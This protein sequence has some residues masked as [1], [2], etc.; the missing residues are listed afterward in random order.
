MWKLFLKN[1]H[2]LLTKK[3]TS[4]LSAAFVIMV[5][6]AASRLL[7]LFRNRV[8]AGYFPVETLSLYFAAFRLP[9][10]IFEILVFGSLSSAFVPTFTDYLSR[11][12]KKEAWYI[13]G[14]SLN[15]WL[16]VFAV[17]GLIVLI[18][19][20]VFY[21]VMAAG[22]SPVE[23]KQIVS[24]ARLLLLAQGFFVVSYFLTGVLES[25]QRFLV[26]AI[27]PLFY[28]LGIIL[29][30]VFL[31]HRLGIFAPTLGAVVGAFLHF[32]V[33]FL[34]AR[35]LGFR[36]LAK[37]DLRHHGVTKIGRLALPRML[38]LTV[39]QV[40]KS[41]ELFLASLVSS[42]AYAYF[43][44]ANSLQ[45]L[46]IGLF[47]VSLSKASL[48]M[49]SK[50]ASQKQWADYKNT[51]LASFREIVF[52]VLPMAVF[53]AVLRI[54]I[55]RLVFGASR[56]DWTATVETG[57][58]L[59][60]FSVGITAQALLY[61]FNRAFYALHDTVTPVKVS[62]VAI[63]INSL[64]GALLV[65]VFRLPVWSLALSFS[66]SSVFQVVILWRLLYRRLNNWS[67]ADFLLPL[68]KVFVAA[69]IAGSL[70][71][72]FLK[73]FDRSATIGVVG[74]FTFALPHGAFGG[75]TLDTRQTGQLLL[76]TLLAGSLG[77]MVYLFLT[78]LLGV[79]EIRV[80]S[81]FAVKLKGRFGRLSQNVS[82]GST[83]IV[84]EET[85]EASSG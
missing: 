48:P 8:L 15:L 78:W 56:F 13:A 64:L 14:A 34:P 16:A 66:I 57:R 61:L 12:K 40:G 74:L 60:A 46:P 32:A 71:F 59:S 45:L 54:P 44:F 39:L 73:L 80:L 63:V 22:F 47:G 85:K 33:Q 41:V 11:G 72:I 4:L 36:F 31:H 5:M 55:V 76:L 79:E 67:L 49:L 82:V 1:S 25:T 3:Q 21:G 68:S 58:T 6:I 20:P 70:V 10:V 65:L 19:A 37:I 50:Q 26:P 9:E 2:H 38:E 62:V 29:G 75:L 18:F 35:H 27:A 23:M 84:H 77:S 28:N 83:G 69:L 24:L 53:L 7:G 42:A 17:F 30:A 43:T 51:F 81:R 52:L